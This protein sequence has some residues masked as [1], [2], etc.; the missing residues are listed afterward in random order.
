MAR[1]SPTIQ[2]IVT[3]LNKLAATQN[4]AIVIFTQ[5]MTKMRTG[6]GAA[7]VPAISIDVWEEGIGTRVALFRD[8]GWEDEDGKS[9][10][11]V[12]LAQVIKVEGVP[13]PGSSSKLV[14][15]SISEVSVFPSATLIQNWKY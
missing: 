6:L 11:D 7:L 8:W 5:C 1:K 14:G 12:R 9:I 4:I 10:D 13:I 3:A 15:F 2:H